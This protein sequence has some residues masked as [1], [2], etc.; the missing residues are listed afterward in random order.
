MR[1]KRTPNRKLGMRGFRLAFSKINTY[2]NARSHIDGG[3]SN[4]WCGRRLS[5]FHGGRGYLGLGTQANTGAGLGAQF[6]KSEDLAR[7]R[8]FYL[9]HKAEELQKGDPS[10]PS[11]GSEL[12]IQAEE[13]LA[14]ARVYRRISDVPVVLPCRLQDSVA[15]TD[16]MHQEVPIWMKS[17]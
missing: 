17:Y 15:R 5:R 7:L 2:A 3:N 16:V 14:M 11:A 6:Q 1:E 13:Q 9:R 4:I 12:D 10:N 8:G